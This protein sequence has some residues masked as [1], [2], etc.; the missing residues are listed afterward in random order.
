MISDYNKIVTERNKYLTE[1]G[2]NNFLVKSLQSRLDNSIKNISA[3]LD[4]FLNSIELKLKNVKI[5][6]DEFDIVYNR[7][8]ENEKTLRSI[9]RELSI[10]EALYLLLLQKE[11]K[12]QLI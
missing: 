10:K 5:K 3:S 2:P 1:A 12:P 4:N 11:R 6:E 7:V 9:E 8:P